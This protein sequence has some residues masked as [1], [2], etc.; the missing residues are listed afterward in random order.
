M[1]VYSSCFLEPNLDGFLIVFRC[2][3]AAQTDLICLLQIVFKVLV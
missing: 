3:L 1:G 2:L